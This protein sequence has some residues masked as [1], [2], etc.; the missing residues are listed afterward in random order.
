MNEICTDNRFEIIERYKHRLIEATNIESNPEE[1]AVLDSILFR[2]WQMGWLK[3][4]VK[5]ELRMSKHGFR[6]WI[7]CGHCY[8]KIYSGDDYC[9]HCGRMV[10]WK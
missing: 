8:G 2:F 5:P 10:R 3:E 1:M 4:P 6:Q 7:V 9:R